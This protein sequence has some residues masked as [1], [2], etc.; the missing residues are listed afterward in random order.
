MKEATVENV[1]EIGTELI[2]QRG[3]NNVGL[4]EILDAAGIPKGSFYYYFQSKEDFGIK[5]IRHYSN[6]SLE[7]LE[8]YL[9]D[10]SKAPLDRI[11]SFFEDMR[12]VYKAKGYTEGC[13][14]GNCSLELSDLKSSFANNLAQELDRWEVLFTQCISEGQATGNINK[15]QSA[16]SVAGFILNS[17]EGALIRMKATHSAQP[18]DN[19]LQFVVKI[20]K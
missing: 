11:V 14:I 5:V 4:K 15:D 20:L 1:L 18:I 12:D 10:D 19:F 13:L 9:G 7:I 8:R 3:Y 17:W 2:A 6:K 16:E